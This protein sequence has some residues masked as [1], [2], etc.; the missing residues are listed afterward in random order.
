M[1]KEDRL[2]RFIEQAKTIYY[3]FLLGGYSDAKD[4]A[5][6]G[7][8]EHCLTEAERLAIRAELADDLRRPQ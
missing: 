2:T 6:N 1:S 7:L 8:F 4:A 3:Y 5:I